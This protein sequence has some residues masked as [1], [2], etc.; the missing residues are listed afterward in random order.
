VRGGVLPCS[1]SVVAP[2]LP[3]LGPIPEFSALA[4]A[5]SERQTVRRVVSPLREV[6]APCVGL[7]EFEQ[8]R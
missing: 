2:R 7:E 4:P 5:G 1:G 6:E 3:R 8:R